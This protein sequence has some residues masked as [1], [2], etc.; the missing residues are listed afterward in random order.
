MNMQVLSFRRR[1]VVLTV[2]LA[3]L[4]GG[5]ADSAS[6]ITFSGQ[7]DD[8]VE[9]PADRSR[10]ITNVATTFDN[11]NGRWTV[12]VTFAGSP[13]AATS[14]RLYTG[15]F[16]PTAQCPLAAGSLGLELETSGALGRYNQTCRQGTPQTIQR[17]LSGSVLTLQ[18]TDP[19]AIGLAPVQL[20]QTRLSEHHLYDLVPATRLFAP[21][22]AATLGVG[23]GT[24]FRIAQAGT[25]R[26]PLSGISRRARASVRLVASGRVLAR[27]TLTV[28][29]GMAQ[30]QLR[31]AAAARR[32]VR[33]S[34]TKATLESKLTDST[35]HTRTVTQKISLIM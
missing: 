17:S 4:V 3:G 10:D 11:T 34:G 2:A 31:L 22:A 19:A 7:I 6:A 8:P 24:R 14:A 18:V 13:T 16:P 29:P 30:L 28:K 9:H 33:A 25:L 12:S 20:G 5:V 1:A 35:G 26:L 32:H 21:T 27:R 23:P 15:I